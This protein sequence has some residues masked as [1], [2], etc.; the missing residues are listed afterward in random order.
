MTTEHAEVSPSSARDTQ[1]PFHH[2]DV[3]EEDMRVTRVTIQIQYV[4]ESQV[5]GQLMVQ[6]EEPE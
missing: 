4:R 1:P 2:G 6:H 3:E 5:P